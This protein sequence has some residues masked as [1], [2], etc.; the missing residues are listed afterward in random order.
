MEQATTHFPPNRVT[1]LILLKKGGSSVNCRV[2]FEIL[3]VEFA[4]RNNPFQ[5][6]IFLSRYAGDVDRREYNFRKC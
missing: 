6:Y 5:A 3:P 2:S 4:H 1:D